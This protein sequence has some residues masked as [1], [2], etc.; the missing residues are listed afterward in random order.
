M[1][2]FLLA[3]PSWSA[4]S[5]GTYSTPTYTYALSISILEGLIWKGLQ[6]LVPKELIWK[7]LGLQ[8]GDG[9]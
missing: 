3:F 4:I 7:G 8:D 2:T 6:Y 5:L 9:E 1:Y